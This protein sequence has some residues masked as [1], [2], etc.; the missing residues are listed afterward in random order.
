MEYFFYCRDRP[1]TRP[2]RHEL[3]EA[4]HSFMDGYA[5]GMIARGPTWSADG[6]TLTGS[7]HI[8]DLPGPDA[9]RVFAFEEPNHRAGVYEEEVLI[10]RWSNTLGRTMWDFVGNS[11]TSVEPARFLILAHARPGATATRDTLH[12][13]QR[14]RLLD[15][16]HGKSLIACGPLHSE[17]A[18]QWLGTTIL[19]EL[20]DHAAAAALLA[21]SPYAQADLYESIEVHSWTFGGRS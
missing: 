4:H 6:L 1:G 2:L 9:A 17:D 19:A 15:G 20:P 16:E 11:G 18:S 13:E 7:M 5:E 14:R 12:E 3:L 10:R 21:Q 8:V